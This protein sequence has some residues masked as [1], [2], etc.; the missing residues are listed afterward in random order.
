MEVTAGRR[1][2]KISPL[3][4]AKPVTLRCVS[5]VS[6][7]AAVR[8]RRGGLREPPLPLHLAVPTQHHPGAAR[9]GHR[10]R[11]LQRM[12]G[13]NFPHDSSV[14]LPHANP[15]PLLQVTS[16]QQD[17]GL[18]PALSLSPPFHLTPYLGEPAG[19]HGAHSP[20]LQHMVLMEQSPAQSPL[21]TGKRV[22][23]VRVRATRTLWG[24]GVHI[25][26]PPCGDRFRSL[27]YRAVVHHICRLAAR[28]TQTEQAPPT[29][30]ITTFGPQPGATRRAELTHPGG[31]IQKK[32]T[33]TAHA[34]AH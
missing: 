24:G 19:G 22:R 23:P 3:C 32:D 13:D 4:G 28:T 20:L 2:S 17:G 8:R 9:H 21:V 31:H 5:G 33:I 11:R 25:P 6:S 7:P 18:Q 10:H 16:T 15:S 27:S 14:V 12:P 34:S 26:P 29:L 1:L 30:T